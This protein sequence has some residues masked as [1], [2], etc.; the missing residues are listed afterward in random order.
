MPIYR[1]SPKFR[2]NGIDWQFNMHVDTSAGDP[3]APGAAVNAAVEGNILP[4]TPIDQQYLGCQVADPHGKAIQ[5]R[6]VPSA[7]QP[8]GNEGA[9]SLPPVC[10]YTISLYD[11][12]YG[13]GRI[14][15]WFFGAVPIDQYAGGL[16]LETWRTTAQTNWD[17]F[18][19]EVNA[20]AGQLVIW[21]TKDSV[22]YPIF[23]IYVQGTLREQKRRE[24]GRSIKG[25]PRT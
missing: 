20:N 21:S 16:L 14:G 4:L 7:A 23:R 24:Y 15:K 6:L 9:I 13:R 1:I 8:F 5:G 25:R 3:S 22:P 10:A 12:V 17:L 2:S 19:A 18:F 11:G